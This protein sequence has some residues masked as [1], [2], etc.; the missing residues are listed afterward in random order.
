MH[1]QRNTGHSYNR[2]KRNR[3]SSSTSRSARGGHLDRDGQWDAH[4]DRGG[5]WDDHRA[6]AA[7]GLLHPTWRILLRPKPSLCYTT[8]RRSRSCRRC[9]PLGTHPAR[10][11]HHR[12][13]QRSRRSI[14]SGFTGAHHSTT[15]FPSCLHRHYPARLFLPLLLHSV[16]QNMCTRLLWGPIE[17]NF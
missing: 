5:Q 11:L 8:T 17:Q 10:S 3:S 15:C 2:R 16:C 13:R 4:L 1:R 12:R 9:S 7:A 14:W 6:A